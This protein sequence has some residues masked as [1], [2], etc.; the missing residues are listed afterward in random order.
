VK[1]IDKRSMH[2][3]LADDLRDAIVSQELEPGELYSVA[4]LA[5]SSGVSRTPVREALITL[6]SQGIVKFERNQGVRIQQSTIHDLEEVFQI[7]LL[8]EVPAV[9]KATNA[10]TPELLEDLRQA[11]QGMKDSVVD[12]NIDRMW[13]YD[14]QFHWLIL[15]ATGNKRLADYVD[16][17]R[18]IVLR[19]GSTT[20]ERSRTTKDIVA[21]HVAVMEPMEHGD[22]HS[23]AVAMFKHIEHTAELLIKQEAEAAETP[24]AGNDIDFGWTAWPAALD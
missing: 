15:H 6:A 16:N 1:A 11:L 23:A 2:E 14:R 18:D 9:R 24:S 4:E 5:K 17:L 21:E 3:R 10:M 7:R 12:S 20:A 8:L 22:P 13:K 19:K